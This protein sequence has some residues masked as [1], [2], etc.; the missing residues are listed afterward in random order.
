MEKITLADTA[1]IQLGNVASL[2]WDS[3]RVLHS[4]DY[5]CVVDQKMV[6]V[7]VLVVWGGWVG[8]GGGGMG[9]GGGG[10]GNTLWCSFI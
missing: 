7:V 4:F 6:V 3:P 10:G 5:T 8:G 1:I 2:Y 9:G